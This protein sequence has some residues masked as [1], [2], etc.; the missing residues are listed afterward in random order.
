MWIIR[1][2]LKPTFNLRVDK[3]NCFHKQNF[4]QTGFYFV[5][6]SVFTL[7]KYKFTQEND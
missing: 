6:L 4:N 3:L 7:K 5:Y 1:F 2:W